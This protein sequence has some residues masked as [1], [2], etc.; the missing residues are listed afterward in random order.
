MSFVRLPLETTFNT[1]DLGG[2]PTRNGNFTKWAQLIRSD[3]V[4][5]VTPHDVDWLKKYGVKTIIDLRSN[6]EREETGYN[7]NPH[8]FSLVHLPLM[9]SE[10]VDDVTKY[11]VDNV[12]MGD[13]YIQFLKEG[14]EKFRQLIEITADDNN[15]GV[16]FHCAAGKDRTGVLAALLL[17]V[18]GAGKGD[19]LANYE[20]TYTYLSQN[21]LFKSRSDYGELLQS[22]R[23]WMEQVLDFLDS[24]YQGSENYLKYYGA[25]KETMEMLRYKCLSF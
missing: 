14:G 7:F 22:R 11:D 13:L 25:K 3:D 23:E 24:E 4:S 6:Q 18:L 8:D 16:L 15:G 2:I 21:P 10:G 19:I 5:K 1:R 9:S 20:T 12:S 17:S